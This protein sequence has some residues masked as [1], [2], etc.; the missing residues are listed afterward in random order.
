MRCAGCSPPVYSPELPPLNSI[1]YREVA[2]FV[3]GEMTLEAAVDLAKR[4]TRQFAKRQMTWFR[5]RARMT[6]VD[7]LKGAEQ[8]LM[9][10]EEFFSR[11][12]AS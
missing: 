9:L 4:K 7:A 11:N 8:A 10:F 12:R 3:R 5:Q 2:A 6:W 1:G